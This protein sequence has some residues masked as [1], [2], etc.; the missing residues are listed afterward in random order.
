ML[1]LASIF[2]S[3]EIYILAAEGALA[4]IAFLI[5]FYRCCCYDYWN[6]RCGLARRG[7]AVES[8]VKGRKKQIERYLN[9]DKFE[10]SWDI[11]VRDVPVK[12]DLQLQGF[13]EAPL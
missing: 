9:R 12:Q 3:F 4:L 7:R 8:Y 5:I 2:F 10:M 13:D 1:P 11:R 6:M